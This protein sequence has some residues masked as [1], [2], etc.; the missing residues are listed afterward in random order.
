MSKKRAS[1]FQQNKASVKDVVKTGSVFQ[2][3]SK[4]K[5]AGVLTYNFSLPAISTC[6]GAG[7]CADKG[8]GFCFAYLEQLRYPSALAYRERMYNLTRSGTMVSVISAEL[9]KLGKKA[10]DQKIAIRIHASGDFYSAGYLLQWATI[11]ELYPNI[12]FYAYTKSIAI[13]KHLQK[14]S[15]TTPKNLILI[16]SLGGK[17]DRL[18]DIEKDRHSRIFATE[19]DALAA[20]YVLASEDDSVAWSSSF[21]KIGLVMFGARAKKGNMALKNVA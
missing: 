18:V 1:I 4:M 11:A 15:W 14:Q 10:K 13:V 12:S 8:K 17:L 2:Q 19:Q 5:K 16:Y 3:N 6:P 21:T 7:V 9:D 20:G